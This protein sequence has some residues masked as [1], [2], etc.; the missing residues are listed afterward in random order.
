MSSYIPR[1]RCRAPA[2]SVVFSDPSD[3]LSIPC[4]P[5]TPPLSLLSPRARLP[6]LTLPL[7]SSIPW[8]HKHTAAS[9]FRDVFSGASSLLI[10]PPT[11]LLSLLS[12]RDHPSLSTPPPL[13]P[14]PQACHCDAASSVIV[15][16]SLPPLSL[17][18]IPLF[19]ASISGNTAWSENKGQTLED[20]QV[21]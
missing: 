12:P 3:A 4:P 20:L 11:P 15:P 6:P 17:S 14:I 5:P 13:F 10:P 7:L 9:A 8:A 18:P 1:S 2:A 21:H 16:K 19:K